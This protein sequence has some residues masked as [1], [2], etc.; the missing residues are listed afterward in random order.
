MQTQTKLAQNRKP[1]GQLTEREAAARD[2]PSTKAPTV[3]AAPRLEKAVPATAAP[4]AATEPP[5]APFEVTPPPS[6]PVAAVVRH[7]IMPPPSRLFF[8]SDVG[9]GPRQAGP[10]GGVGDAAADVAPLQWAAG[11]AAAEEPLPW[12]VGHTEQRAGGDA[13]RQ[14]PARVRQAPGAWYA[15]G[16]FSWERRTGLPLR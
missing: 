15:G 11:D 5:A 13:G 14:R 16:A 6:I 1:L 7:S 4:V 10:R 8:L 9:S 3:D 2:V 12:Q